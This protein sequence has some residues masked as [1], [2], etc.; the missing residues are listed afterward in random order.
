MTGPIL[1]LGAS[2]TIARSL[3]AEYARSGAP[4][5]LAGRDLGELGRTA[6][7]LRL[8][9]RVEVR[10]APCDL[11]APD[12][13]QPL[14]SALEPLPLLRGVIWAFGTMRAA[15]GSQKPEAL[16]ASAWVNFGAAPLVIEAL[17]AK[18]DPQGFIAFLS[19]VAGD[20]GRQANYVYGAAKAAL[21][22][23]ALGLRHRLHNQGPSITVVRLGVVDTQMTWGY[24]TVFG[25]DPDGVARAILQGVARRR[26]VLYVPRKWAL[27]MAIIRHLPEPVFNRL[28]I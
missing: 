22:T 27:V 5:V 9:H 24:P 28:R 7:D 14:F 18:I 4:L 1:V 12:Y 11:F 6:Q 19:S 3:A 10:T 16:R 2:S 23:Y 8:R 21:G 17:L 25:A 20:R 26:A 13:P 15:A